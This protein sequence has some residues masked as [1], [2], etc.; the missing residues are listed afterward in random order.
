MPVTD[1][2]EEVLGSHWF[3]PNTAASTSLELPHLARYQLAS[4]ALRQAVTPVLLLA[5]ALHRFQLRTGGSS[6]TDAATLAAGLERVMDMVEAAKAL[7]ACRIARAASE[8][9]SEAFEAGMAVM[10]NWAAEVNRDPRWGRSESPEPF[11]AQFTDLC[12][13]AAEMLAYGAVQGLGNK[14]NQS[15]LQLGMRLSH[16]DLCHETEAQS[17]VYYHTAQIYT[18]EWYQLCVFRDGF[19]GG[20]PST[21]VRLLWGFLLVTASRLCSLKVTHLVDY[22]ITC[23]TR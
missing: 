20:G 1:S 7:Q 4:V 2:N 21:V 6:D 5:A 8:A 13:G 3:L 11:G 23:Q 18:I 19:C 16:V 22:S 9:G 12:F 14:D 15:L 17:A 10:D